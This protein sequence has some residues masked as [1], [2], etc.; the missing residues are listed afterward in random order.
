MLPLFLSLHC[1][2]KERNLNSWSS[3]CFRTN[4][5]ST[6][7]FFKKRKGIFKFTKQWSLTSKKTFLLCLLWHLRCCLPI[8]TGPAKPVRGRPGQVCYVDIRGQTKSGWKE[9]PYGSASQQTGLEDPT[10]RK[11]AAKDSTYAGNFLWIG[12][13]VKVKVSARKQ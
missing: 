6:G 4:Q 8:C 2:S 9:H 1:G 7:H 10:Q 13:A 3:L 11:T 5:Q 12:F